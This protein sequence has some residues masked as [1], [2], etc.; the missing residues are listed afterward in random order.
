MSEPPEQLFVFFNH[1]HLAF[2]SKGVKM[3]YVSFQPIWCSSWYLNYI[4]IYYIDMHSQHMISNASPWLVWRGPQTI[5]IC[6]AKI[7]W[8]PQKTQWSSILPSWECL[9]VKNQLQNC[10]QNSWGLD[11][12][13]KGKHPKLE[14]RLAKIGQYLFWLLGETKS[15]PA[16][17]I[18]N[19]KQ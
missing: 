11:L 5:E 13:P 10:P 4:Y 18:E 7:S 1:R 2:V 9:S 19:M 3:S 8:Y 14:G 12:S 16:C 17:L 6:P 15:L